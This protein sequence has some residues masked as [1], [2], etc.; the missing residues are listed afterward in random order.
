[1]LSFWHVLADLFVIIAIILDL[2]EFAILLIGKY[3]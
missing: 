2:M 3:I 1:M